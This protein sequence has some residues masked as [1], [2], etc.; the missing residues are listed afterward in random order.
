MTKRAVAILLTLVL[1]ASLFS[2]CAKKDGSNANL[3]FP[4]VLE[5][6]SLDPQIADT[7]ADILIANCFEGLVRMGEDGEILP[8]V[9]ESWDVS[10][11]GLEYT[12]RLRNNAKWHLTDDFENIL[13]KDFKHTFKNTVTAH[14]FVFGFR[15]VVMPQTASPYAPSLFMIKNAQA[16]NNSTVAVEQLGIEATDDFTL[17]ITL[18]A[19]SVDFFNLLTS[20]AC[21]PCSEAFFEATKGKYGL[22]DDYLLCNGPFYLSVW[23]EGSSLLLRKNGDYAGNSPVLPASVTL[24]IT[25]D[26]AQHAQKITQGSFSAAPVTAK[27]AATLTAASGVTLR[28]SQNI[29]QAIC[30]NCSDPLLSKPSVRLALCKAID[31]TGLGERLSGPS[32]T[33][34]II[35]PCCT[36]GQ[37]PFKDLANTAVPPGFDPAGAK[38]LW[39]SALNEIGEEQL[40]LTVLCSPEFEVEM[41]GL[42]QIWQKT[43]GIGLS[44][45]VEVVEPFEL[46]SRVTDGKYQIALAPVPANKSSA[47]A[48]LQNFESGS[49]GNILNYSSDVYDGIMGQI[50]TAGTLSETVRLCESAQN[51]L[52]LNGAVSPLFSQASYLALAKG[53]SDIYTSPAGERVFF[54]GGKAAE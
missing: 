3:S 16:V 6:R 25:A 10:A 28:E 34:S 36:V 26:P 9:A 15:R 48:F 7:S 46:Q 50:R 47:A 44:I 2:A 13:G 32:A 45:S 14:D 31:K 54:I 51:H 27:D 23:N 52:L 24:R 1:T 11:D 35:P 39:D 4:I 22:G 33:G 5:P 49:P 18:A 8:G 38:N 40:A 53:V 43:L 41:R 21:M 29:I 19:A 12:F 42:L 20:P 30:Y 17:R 37:T